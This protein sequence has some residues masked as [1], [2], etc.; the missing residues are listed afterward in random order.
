MSPPQVLLTKVQDVLKTILTK[1]KE[2]LEPLM[3][4]DV[5]TMF[6]QLIAVGEPEPTGIIREV[7]R[8]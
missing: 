2:V 1:V 4:K 6:K 7:R 8:V 5:L 3:D